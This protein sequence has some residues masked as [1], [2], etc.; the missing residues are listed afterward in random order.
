MNNVITIIKDIL[1]Y[2]FVRAQIHLKK[3]I[4]NPIQ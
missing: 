3:V 1:C 2:I 4:N